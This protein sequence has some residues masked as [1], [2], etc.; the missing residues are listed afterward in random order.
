L[1]FG[2]T[3][4][5]SDLMSASETKYRACGLMTPGDV[6][7]RTAGEMQA[8]MPSPAVMKMASA[9]SLQILIVI[10]LVPCHQLQALDQCNLLTV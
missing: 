5:L 2:L 8:P 10:A 7:Q 1:E 3:Q 9:D 6:T 4:R